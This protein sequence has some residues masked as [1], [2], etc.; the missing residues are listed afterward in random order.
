MTE[1]RATEATK[2][3]PGRPKGLPRTGGRAKGTPNRTNQITRDFIVKNG[4]PV[5]F[6]CSVVKGR[7]FTSA[8]E[9]GD[10]K[11]THV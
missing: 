4:A 8:K 11:R 6:L 2:R 10:A 9:P 1:E 3:K 7:R 5:A